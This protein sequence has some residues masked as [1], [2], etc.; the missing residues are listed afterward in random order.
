MK[1]IHCYASQIPERITSL[2]IND[3]QLNEEDIQELIRTLAHLKS[4][5]IRSR[6]ADY[7]LLYLSNFTC[8]QR[9][10]FPYGT[11][12]AIITDFKKLTHL[13][14]LEMFVLEKVFI[15]PSYDQ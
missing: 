6:C 10:G 15:D 7:V 13:T 12:Q 9:L 14:K 11:S 1:N 4:L 8:L 5:T 2:V 3:E